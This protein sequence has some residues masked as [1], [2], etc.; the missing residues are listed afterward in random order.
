M[1]LF[2]INFCLIYDF[3]VEGQRNTVQLSLDF[4][5]FLNLFNSNWGINKVYIGSNSQVAPLSFEGRDAATGKPIVSMRKI[6]NEYMT[7]GFQD[8][9]SVSSTWNLQ[10]GIKYI[11]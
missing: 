11:F 2:N 6:N 4:I 10:F 3:N 5:N 7:T 9:S 1:L 8:P